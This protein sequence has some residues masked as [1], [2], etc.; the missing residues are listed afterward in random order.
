MN[1]SIIDK[2][3]TLVNRLEELN[4]LISLEGATDDIELFKNTIEIAEI[5]PVVELFNKFKKNNDEIAELSKLLDDD[6]LKVLANDEIKQKNKEI[7][8]IELSCKKL[9]SKRS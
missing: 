7:I 2:L 5:T 9:N 4:H 6:E 1:Q 8:E 3:E